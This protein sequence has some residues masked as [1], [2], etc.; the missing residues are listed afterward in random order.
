MAGAVSGA[1][2]YKPVIGDEQDR[3]ALF[4]G[5]GYRTLA[6]GTGGQYDTDFTSLF[7]SVTVRVWPWE[8]VLY[9]FPFS[10]QENSE[11]F[12]RAALLDHNR[13]P[14]IIHRLRLKT[15]Q[16]AAYIFCD[17]PENSLACMIS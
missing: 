16:E 12:D 11:F 9:D 17:R 13:L 10:C 5:Y 4:H 6:A 1:I 14:G 8:S 2:V 7:K 3:A 15:G